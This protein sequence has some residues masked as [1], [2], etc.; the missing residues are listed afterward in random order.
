[1]IDYDPPY[2][3]LGQAVEK[4]RRRARKGE[5]SREE[6]LAYGE[7]VHQAMLRLQRS[8]MKTRLGLN[9][10][11]FRPRCASGTWHNDGDAIHD[12]MLQQQQAA[13]ARAPAVIRRRGIP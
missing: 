6:R 12:A 5:L 11:E 10:A 4:W 2:P 3:K 7:A 13:L 9:P 1:M 8:E